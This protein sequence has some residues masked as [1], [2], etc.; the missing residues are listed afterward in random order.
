MASCYG[1]PQPT[2]SQYLTITDL[3]LL[4]TCLHLST[5]SWTVRSNA[6]RSQRTLISQNPPSG[7][8]SV[9]PRRRRLNWCHVH[10]RTYR[11]INLVTDSNRQVARDAISEDRYTSDNF[12]L[13]PNDTKNGIM[14]L[15]LWFRHNQKIMLEI[16]GTSARGY[17]QFTMNGTWAFVTIDKCCKIHTSHPLPNLVF[18]WYDRVNYQTLILGWQHISHVIGNVELVSAALCKR[19]CSSS[20]IQ[21]LDLTHPDHVVRHASYNEEYHSHR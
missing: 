21:A 14:S 20:L 17:L 3:T 1:L 13:K 4:D 2:V 9:H 8:F 12:T 10:V 19:P 6:S 7:N 15:P 18:D 16:D 5:S 11:S